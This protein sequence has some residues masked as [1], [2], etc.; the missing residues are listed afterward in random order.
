[1]PKPAT[2]HT[3]CYKVAPIDP[4]A[5]HVARASRVAELAKEAAA[6]EAAELSTA[7]AA[8]EAAAAEA[9]SACDDSSMS[10]LYHSYARDC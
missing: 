6:R 3:Q 4:D 5:T 8:S 7:A 9:E 2:V 1:M 10:P